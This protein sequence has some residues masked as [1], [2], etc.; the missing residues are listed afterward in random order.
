VMAIAVILGT[1]A[2]GPLDRRFNTRRGVVMA[3]AL[4]TLIPLLVLAAFPAGGIWSAT[5]LLA[6]FG[7]LG[8][9]SLVVMAHGF[10]LVPDR[11]AGRGAAVLNTALMGGA[12]LLQDSTGRLM[13]ALPSSAPPSFRYAV[14]FALLAGLTGAALVVY[15]RA[16]DVKPGDPVSGVAPRAAPSTSRVEPL[17]IRAYAAEK[18]GKAEKRWRRASS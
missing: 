4:A 12:G 9:Y 16:A 7:L 2:Y 13:V 10:A 8:S 6:L 3:G 14:F 17:A 1:F 11:L 15:R 5:L 18:P